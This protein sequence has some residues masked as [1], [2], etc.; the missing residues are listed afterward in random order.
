MKSKNIIFCSIL[1]LLGTYTYIKGTS[2]CSNKI[3][4]VALGDSITKGTGDPTR[5]GYIERVKIKLESRL[6]LPV[7]LS[8]YAIPKYTTDD[9]LEQIQDRKILEDL[10]EST[11]MV[12]YVGTNDFRKSTDHIFNPLN[13]KQLNNGRLTFTNNLYKIIKIMKRENSSAP[14]FV[15]GLYHPYVEYQNKQEILHEINRWNSAMINVFKDFD[16][17]FF[18]PT[19]DLFND[20]LKMLYFSDSLHPNPAGYQLI[21]D[22]LFSHIETTVSE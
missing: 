3:N 19:L 6:D 21:A 22:R 10:Q 8:N 13:I 11:H 16:Q 2:A 5:Q 15:L 7:Q 20:K 14:I 17:V 4:L 1:L 12:L 9:I 18:V